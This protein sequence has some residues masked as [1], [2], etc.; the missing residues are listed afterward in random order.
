MEITL[1]ALATPW[2]IHEEARL[3]S[4]LSVIPADNYDPWIRVGLALHNLE[5]DRS[6]GTSIAYDL[7]AEWSATSREK[8]CLEACELKWGSFDRSRS[9]GRHIT[10]ASIFR[11]AKQHGWINEM[12]AHAQPHNIAKSTGTDQACIAKFQELAGLSPVEYDKIRVGEAEKIG[13]RV[14]TLDDEVSKLRDGADS[15]SRAG[16]PLALPMPE[17][18]ATSIDGAELIRELSHSITRYVMLSK[19]SAVA[20]ALWVVHA[21]AFEASTITPRLAITSPEKRCGKTTLLRIIQVLVPRPLSA[22]NITAA[23]MFRTVEMARPTLLIDEAD[24]FLAAN[25][26]LRGILNSGHSNDGNVIRLVGDDHEPRAFSTWCPTAIAAIGRLPNTIEDRS[27]KIVMR[28]RR[29]DEP[30]DRIGRDQSER[31]FGAWAKVATVGG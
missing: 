5:W 27:I 14:G 19:E 2:S 26:E 8:F 11:L 22:A 29:R 12:N 6:D 3:R 30:V 20:I 15:S 1:E 21:Y 24:T 13:I 28:R 23:A 7:W 9:D 16:R 18:W 17:P 10:Q 4:A 31:A 25:E